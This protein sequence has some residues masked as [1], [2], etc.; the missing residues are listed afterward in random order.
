MPKKST[1]DADLKSE[2][3]DLKAIAKEEKQARAAL[4]KVVARKRKAVSAM[5]KKGANVSSMAAIFGVTRQALAKD[6]RANSPAAKAAAK[7]K[8]ADKAE[9]KAA[10]A[11]PA[12]ATEAKAAK[13]VVRKVKAA[14]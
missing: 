3:A 5:S 4:D 9:P 14:A 13:R 8:A 2:F 7:A 10:K 11:K 1:P 12:K 6:I